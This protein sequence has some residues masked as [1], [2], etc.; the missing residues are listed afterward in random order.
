MT[1]SDSLPYS[2][3]AV[4]LGLNP[5]GL[6]IVRSLTAAGIPVIGVDRRPIG[7]WDTNIWMSSRTRLC[8]RV[9][10]DPSE[11]DLLQCLTRLGQSMQ[12]PGILFPAG[13]AEL[14][15][16]SRNRKQLRN[17]FEFRIPD[18]NTVELLADKARFYDVCVEHNIPA[19]GT[20]AGCSPEDISERASE[21]EYPCLIKP[22]LRDRAWNVEFNDRKVLVADSQRQLK[23][24]YDRAYEFNNQLLVQEIVPGPD[25]NLYFSHVYLSESLETLAIWT[26]RKIRQRP[27]HFGTSTMTETLWNDEI[28]ESTLNL[29]RALNCS[30]YSSIEYKKDD[31]DGLFKI[32]EVTQGRTWY[33]HFL[34]F[35]AGVNIPEVWYRDIAGF[36]PLST[37]TAK[38]GIRWIDECRD[39][40][41]SYA[42]WKNGELTFFEWI[43]SHRR[44]SVFAFWSSRDPMPMLYVIARTIV[45]SVALLYRQ[46]LGRVL[47]F[48]KTSP[49]TAT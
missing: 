16:L 1:N 21:L 5:N 19:P 2:T 36:D 46:T 27:I 35:G 29:L 15:C 18:T 39:P 44:V 37:Q 32:M 49:D 4:V 45:Q 20:L 13:D 9:F 8:R 43:K 41:A 14:L 12:T 24:L 42:Y 17:Y 31:R 7:V 30:G 38:E 10:Y 25:S 34:G 6:G 23:E 26:G 28:A 22:S 48:R 47:P 3:T 33:P 40:A 11:S